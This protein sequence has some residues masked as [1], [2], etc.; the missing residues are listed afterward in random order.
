M[1]EAERFRQEGIPEEAFQRSKRALYGEIVSA[2]NN[3]SSIANG[4][5]NMHLKGRELFAYI[6]SLAT[7]QAKDVQEKLEQV[8][9]QEQSVLSVILPV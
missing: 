8:F 3:T 5:V 6:D 4:L 1:K 9:V 7:L 2:L